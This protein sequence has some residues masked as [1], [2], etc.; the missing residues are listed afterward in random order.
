MNLRTAR[1]VIA[2]DAKRV[3][4]TPKAFVN[5][6]TVLKDL[7]AEK[8]GRGPEE[9]H[10]QTRGGLKIN[11]PNR[12]GARVPI[13]EIFAEDCYRLNWFV[14]GLADHAFNVVD[15]GGHVGTFACRLAQLFPQATIHSFE[16]SATTAEFYR[17]NVE[18]NGFGGRVIVAQKAV[19][20]E[21]G[22]AIFDDNGAG[23]GT[24]GLVKDGSRLVDVDYN[25]ASGRT[26]EVATVGFDAVMADFDGPV[27]VVKI[28]CEGAEYDLIYG[29]KPETWDPVRRLV[30]EYH[31]VDDNS[32]DELKAYFAARGLNVVR[33][34]PV[35]D[36]LGT[37]WL[38]RDPLGPD[39]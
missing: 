33:H 27:E 6:P 35:N 34:E 30:L 19:A 3:A 14:G 2:L 5:W 4:Q 31:E 7:A 29:S 1:L 9:L 21:E 15:I 37:A 8:L 20:R 12:P 13:Y 32:W 16:P 24:N 18:Q 23:S 39:H 36:R 38:S 26:V 17:R 10:F 28:D 11:T 25:H 22:I